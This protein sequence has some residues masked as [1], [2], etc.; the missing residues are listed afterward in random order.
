MHLSQHALRLQPLA[1]AAASAVPAAVM[2]TTAAAVLPLA[3]VTR[4]AAVRQH[5][6]RQMTRAT[7]TQDLLPWLLLALTCSNSQHVSQRLSQVC[8]AWVQDAACRSN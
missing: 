5:P 1:A 2:M 7:M 6:L 3:V 8:S 4:I